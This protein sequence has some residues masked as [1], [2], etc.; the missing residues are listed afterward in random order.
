MIDGEQ[1]SIVIAA[2]GSKKASVSIDF[3]SAAFTS[4]NSDSPQRCVLTFAAVADVSGS[5]DPTPE[6]NMANVEV[7]VR[8]LND[9][10]QVAAPNHESTVASVRPIR[11]RI[12][13]GQMTATKTIRLKVINAD[14]DEDG[15]TVTATIGSGTCVA[16]TLPDFDRTVAGDQNITTIGGGDMKAARVTL[17]VHRDD[18]STDSTKSPRRCVRQLCA[19]GPSGNTE[20][21][22]SNDCTELTVDVTDQ[23]DF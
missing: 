1:D 18:I 7:S 13:D 5:V 9:P 20:P 21:N 6:N 10:E 16:A 19:T 2:G 15:H 17:T 11:L 22:T 4:F 3:P 23:N 8:D 12:S 14:D